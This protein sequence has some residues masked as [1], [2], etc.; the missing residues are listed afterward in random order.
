MLVQ[1]WLKQLVYSSSQMHL[2][3]VGRIWWLFSVVP[4]TLLW[5]GE[6]GLNGLGYFAFWLYTGFS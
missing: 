3:L 1:A 2:C 4:A 5:R 6:A